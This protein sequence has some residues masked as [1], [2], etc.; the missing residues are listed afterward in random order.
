MT[1]CS[2]PI[3][4]KNSRRWGCCCSRYG[5]RP[6]VLALVVE[7]QRVAERQAVLAQL[8]PE[9]GGPAARLLLPHE[10]PYEG[11]LGPQPAVHVE[12]LPGDPA[13]PG[14]NLVR[15]LEH[16]DGDRPRGARLVLP[17]PGLLAHDVCEQL[18]PPRPFGGHG[19]GLVLLGP[20]LDLHEGTREQIVVPGGMPVGPARGPDDEQVPAAGAALA[21]EAERDGVRLAGPGSGGGEKD[22][23]GTFEG[24]ADA[25]GVR[26]E[27]FDDNLIERCCIE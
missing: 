27:L 1:R 22:Q 20:G 5:K 3:R 7:L 19:D 18:V 26:P 10:F 25:A 15:P 17:V 9:R 12:Q 6:A 2:A 4:R 14:G 24:P 16:H 21:D 11:Q 8:Q 13:L 23:L